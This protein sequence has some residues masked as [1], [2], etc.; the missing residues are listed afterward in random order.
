MLC[1][2]DKAGLVFL[3]LI[4]GGA[5]VNDDGANP[6]LKIVLG[7]FALIIGSIG[8]YLFIRFIKDPSR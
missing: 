3:A 4:L 6:G 8:I 7:V 2:P 1:S 5:A